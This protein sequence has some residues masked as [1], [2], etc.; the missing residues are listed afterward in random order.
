MSFEPQI[1]G[2]LAHVQAARPVANTQAATEK[3]LR[4]A[5]SIAQKAGTT[6]PKDLYGNRAALS[7]WIEAHKPKTPDGRFANYPSSKQVAFAERIARIKRRDIPRECF[8]DKG[9]MS[10][11]I[12]GNKPR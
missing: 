9:M 3:Q 11:W 6:L 1:P 10:K 7:A 8:R 4:Y 12:D 2:L 5:Q